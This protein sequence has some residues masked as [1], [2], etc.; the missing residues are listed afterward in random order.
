MKRCLGTAVAFQVAAV[1]A[2]AMVAGTQAPAARADGY[3]LVASLNTARQENAG[4]LLRGRAYAVGGLGSGNS[5][6]DSVER[7]DPVSNRWSFVA[8]LPLTRH[9]PG[10]AT[11]EG[12][13]G[14]PD[15]LYVVGGY[16][17]EFTAQQEVF[18]YDPDHNA[19]GRVADLPEPRAAGAAVA[20]GGLVYFVGGLN[21]AGQSSRTLFVYDP[22]AD[23]WSRGPDMPSARDHVAVAAVGPDLYAIG[24]RNAGDS[25]D[26]NELFETLQGRWSTR[27][28]LPTAR[29]A[30]AAAARGGRIYVIGGETPQL[31]AANEI[32]DVQQNTWSTSTS[33]PVPRHGMAAALLPDGGF[34]LA[35][36]G[37]AQGWQ[38]TTYA[39]VFRV[40]LTGDLNC[41]ERVNSTD[42]PA[43]VLI[44]S[45]PA[46]Y[47][48][49]H[50]SCPPEN[51]DVNGDGRVDFDDIPG[52]VAALGQ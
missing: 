16:L 52:F 28:P 3:T 24:G 5:V 47:R 13:A 12:R 36:G 37:T 41:D 14:L 2:G 8:D 39:D 51:G 33:M 21:G 7:Y 44:L 22:A 38:P 23:R 17:D 9:H 40:G 32:Y 49:T 45:D 19:W 25:T 48:A 43:F 29:A 26:A 11:I 6:L 34:L 30:A 50:P 42:V 10:V 1:L 35:G 20:I 31:F 18:A 46:G 15:R 4:A 27:A